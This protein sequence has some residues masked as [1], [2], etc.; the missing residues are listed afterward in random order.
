MYGTDGSKLALMNGQTLVKAVVPLAGGVQAV[1][2]P[3]GLAYYRDPDW[4]GSVRLDSSPSRAVVSDVAYTGCGKT[5]QCCQPERGEGSRSEHFQGNARF[6]VAAAPQSGR[7]FEFF[8]SLYSPYG[9]C[10]AEAGGGT[11]DC[12][13]A[14]M[15]QDTVSTGSYPLYD[16]LFRE[17]H[18]I[19]GRWISPDPVG[20]A[21]VD[22]SNP[23][24]WNRYAYVT[25]NPLALTDPLGLQECD[26]LAGPC[27]P[28]CDPVTG[29]CGP[30]DPTVVNC[31]PQCDPGDPFCGQGNGSGGGGIPPAPPQIPIPPGG[32]IGPI[33]PYPC[34][35]D[36]SAGEPNPCTGF[37]WWW[38]TPAAPAIITLDTIFHANSSARAPN[39]NVQ[40]TGPLTNSPFSSPI[41]TTSCSTYSAGGRLD[42]AFICSRFPNSPRF[43]FIRGWRRHC[44]VCLRPN[45]RPQGGNS[46]AP[47]PWPS[48]G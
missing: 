40:P 3:G 16:G 25:N 22:P 17:Y 19:W 21:A 14:G 29:E 41:T 8:R 32:P 44:L 31:L 43:N 15:N 47:F 36:P 26:P 18:P 34:G 5:L 23:Q 10:Y 39:S 12:T 27:P 6:F 37:H 30:C 7:A 1:Y 20:L 35:V 2:N 4:L 46:H 13:F 9:E 48:S 45:G 38:F 42:L 24:T 28:S 33:N 11:P